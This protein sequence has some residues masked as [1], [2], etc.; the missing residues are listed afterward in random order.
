ME[1]KIKTLASLFKTE[2][3]RLWINNPQIDNLTDIVKMD[4]GL[5]LTNPRLIYML[6]LETYNNSNKD[7]KAMNV[8]LV[9]EK[10]LTVEMNPMIN[11]L[12]IRSSQADKI[13]KKINDFFPYYS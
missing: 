2:E 5:E 3:V 8:L 10:S 6:S 11:L 13:L 4:K 12:W 1:T 9:S 7:L